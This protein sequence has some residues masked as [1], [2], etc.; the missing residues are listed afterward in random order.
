MEQ[1]SS[2]PPDGLIYTPFTSAFPRFKPPSRQLV[3]RMWVGFETPAEFDCMNQPS[4][5]ACVKG[6]ESR[7]LS[8]ASSS[9][10]G[11]VY[12]RPMPSNCSGVA[13]G[14]LGRS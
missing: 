10:G 9:R 7:R 2:E 4:R 1:H 14:P 12:C 3:V 5:E 8:P 13:T 11:Q 6:L